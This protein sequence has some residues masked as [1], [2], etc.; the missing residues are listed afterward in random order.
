MIFSTRSLLFGI[1]A[2]LCA[3]ALAQTVPQVKLS[4]D[5]PTVSRV[6]AGCLRLG[7][8]RALGIADQV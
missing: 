3:V 8:V 5:G 1:L 2:Y 7:Q 4:P 6:G